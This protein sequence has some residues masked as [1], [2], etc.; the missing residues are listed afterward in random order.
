MLL[1]IEHLTSYRYSEKIFLEPQHLYFH[2]QYR[3]HL[4]LIKHELQVLP[5]PA[6]S[7]VRIDVENNTYTQC[8]FNET[9]DKLEISL[10]M[11]VETSVFNQFNFLLEEQPKTDYQEALGLYL[12]QTEVLNQEVQDWLNNIASADPNNFISSLCLAINNKWSHTTSDESELL[13]LNTCFN[14]DSGSCRDLSWMMIQML[15]SKNI[16]ARYVSGYSHNPELVGHELHA[17]V[18]AWLPGAGWIGLDPSSGLFITEF[19]IPMAS[20]YHPVNTLPI[21]GSFRGTAKAKLDT[22]VKIAIKQ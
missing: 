14:Q 15:R 4:K 2:P 11:L 10:K 21:Q 8:W 1:E 18:E 13:D 12:T 3:S 16:P 6:G 19:Y 7:G 17:W 5:N 20:S 9:T 22:M